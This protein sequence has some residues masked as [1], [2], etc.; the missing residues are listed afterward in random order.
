MKLKLNHIWKSC[1]KANVK[2]S[3]RLFGNLVENHSLIQVNIKFVRDGN[4]NPQP[5]IS[6]FFIN[7]KKTVSNFSR[8]LILVKKIP[9]PHV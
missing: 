9:D 2:R 4:P 6:L 7:K 5:G 3:P 1:H 8:F